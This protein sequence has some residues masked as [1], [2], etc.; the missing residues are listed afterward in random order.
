MDRETKQE[1]QKL[2]ERL[3][4]GDREAFH[5]LYEMLWPLVHRFAQKALP[6]SPDA[7]DVAQ[8]SL[9]KV[10]ARAAEFDRDRDALSWILG[11]TAYEC[12]TFRQTH[13]RRREDSSPE[14]IHMEEGPNPEQNAI[15]RDLEMAALDVLGTLRPIDVETIRAMMDD[16]KPEVPSATFRKRCERAIH[17]LRTA[18]SSR[19]GLD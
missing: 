10:F 1:L 16:R 14:D 6:G 11:V 5:P 4:E 2:M 15:A 3:A 18:W 7:D 19:H 13:R 9:M 17:R 12:R 8:V